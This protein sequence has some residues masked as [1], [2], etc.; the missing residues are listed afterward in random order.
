MNQKILLVIADGCRL[1]TDLCI[2]KPNLY[3][4]YGSRI[5][6]K[7]PEVQLRG[8]VRFRFLVPYQV[9]FLAAQDLCNT[10]IKTLFQ[11]SKYHRMLIFSTQLQTIQ[12]F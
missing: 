9:P 7:N 4:A 3:S 6:N 1:R 8:F 12:F 5:K 10:N 11:N 2:V